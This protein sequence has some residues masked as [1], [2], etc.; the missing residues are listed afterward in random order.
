MTEQHN[1]PEQYPDSETLARI[2]QIDGA[3]RNG[4]SNLSPEFRV[5]M[6][7]LMAPIWRKIMGQDL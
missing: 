1:N 5:R 7:S 2:V 3:I 6:A 4:K